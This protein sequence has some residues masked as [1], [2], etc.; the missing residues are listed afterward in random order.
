MNEF[1]LP[2][3]GT[4]L[5]PSQAMRLAINEAYKGAAR[6]SPNP[7]VGSVVVDANGL[8]MQAGHH[9]FFGGAHAEVN[10]LKGLTPEQLKGATVYV[11]LEP[12][13]HEGKT[14]SCAKMLT[15]VPIKKVIFGL[16]DPNPLV[17]GQGVDILR[18]AG[19]EVEEFSLA[20]GESEYALIRQELEKVCEAFL[21]NFR[22]KKVFVALKLASSLDGKI[23]LKDGST[24]WLTGD[25]SRKQVHYLRSCYDAI[26]VGKETFK[27]DNPQLNVRYGYDKTL[28]V[29]ILDTRGECFAQYANSALAKAHDVKNVYWVIGK[30]YQSRVRSV[31]GDP[32]LV[33]V[34]TGEDGHVS[35]SGALDE[36]YRLGVRSLFVEGGG[37][38]A[39]Q[40]VGQGLVNRLYL[41]FAPKILGR[42]IAWTEALETE[43]LDQKIKVQ[44]PQWASFGPDMML[45]GTL[46][47]NKT[48]LRVNNIHSQNMKWVRSSDGIFL[49]VC[50][51]LAQSFGISAGI[52]RALWLLAIFGLGTGFLFYFILGLSLPREDKIPE[53]LDGKFLG[54][55]ARIARRYRIEVGIVRLSFVLTALF[56]FGASVLVYGIGYFVVVD[57]S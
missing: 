27:K 19:I 45:T 57:E 1:V 43:T 35:L 54:V 51:G 22:H 30:K 29:F 55:C 37:K 6:V 7:L 56:T 39:E 14:A 5:N 49:G 48:P 4:A 31:T 12:C 3:V 18:Q 40:F 9:E 16:I 53:A 24:T 17:A 44:S 10:A 33:F 52:M 23:G 15:Q 25:E 20:H 38:V 36:M 13:A 26:C 8:F 11:T 50:K 32:Q 46:D 47:G 34:D 41:F 2:P 42:G 28:K 21:W